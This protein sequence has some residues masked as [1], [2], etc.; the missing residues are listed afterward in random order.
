MTDSTIPNNPRSNK[1]SILSWTTIALLASALLMYWLHIPNYLLLITA[2]VVLLNLVILPLF[3]AFQLK[4]TPVCIVRHILFLLS[5]FLFNLAF[6]LLLQK[7]LLPVKVSAIVTIVTGVLIILYFIIEIGRGYMQV[8]NMSFSHYY[9]III[10]LLALNLPAELQFPDYRYQPTVLKPAY[11]EG[12]GP[13][14]YID[15]AHNNIHTLDHRLVATGKLLER[16]GYNLQALESKISTGN[17]LEGCRIYM[18]VNPLNDKDVDAWE[19]P[20]YSAFT[21]EEIRHIKDW[22]YQGG[23][24]ML[25]VDHMPLP[26][27]A[28]DLAVAF[29]FELKNGHAKQIPWR[30]NW[31]IREDSA[32]SDNVVTNGRR[33]G[34]SVDSVLAF[35]GSAFLIPEDAVSIMTLDSAW[36]QWEPDIVWDFRLEDRYS[37]AGYSMGAYKEYG[38]GKVVVYS[39]AMMFTAQ[40]G[41]GLSWVKLGMNSNHQPENHMLLLNTIHW[42]DG[43]M[44]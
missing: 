2:G 25:I 41:G 20:T 37:A 43:L 14:I 23:S 27:A 30:D 17:D 12:V 7:E 6:C 4:K 13:V 31:F 44:D 29:G 11:A 36:Y 18:I 19:N 35:G 9:L 33:E 8:T 42:L 39:E 24:L 16:D 15:Q 26:G 3:L 40:L 5:A 22:V 28:Y 1:V 32:L 38:N 10:I 34:E 21:S